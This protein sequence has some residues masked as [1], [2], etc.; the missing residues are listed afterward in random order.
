M[1]ID[2]FYLPGK[3]TPIFLPP[4]IERLSAA[5]G[6]PPPSPL[7]IAVRDLPSGQIRF[8]E[9]AAAALSGYPKHFSA[10]VRA[11]IV[12]T[13]RVPKYTARLHERSFTTRRGK[14]EVEVKRT[15]PPSAAMRTDAIRPESEN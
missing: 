15:D 9:G 4:R 11:T 2:S 5:R 13:Q 7:P 6:A 10:A 1:A 14:G 8:F 12:K 3:G